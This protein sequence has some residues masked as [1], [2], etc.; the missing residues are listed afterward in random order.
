MS[1]FK[2][3][4]RASVISLLLLTLFKI[5]GGITFTIAGT[6][7][8]QSDEDFAFDFTGDDDL[9]VEVTSSDETISAIRK[10]W[11]VPD[12]ITAYVGK[13]FKF[14]FPSDAFTKGVKYYEVSNF[15]IFSCYN[16]AAMHKIGSKQYGLNF[17][18]NITRLSVSNNIK[19]TLQIIMI[20][21]LLLL[22]VD[23]F[24]Y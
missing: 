9:M 20:F 21:L 1:P 3:V 12:D 4:W 7:S 19:Q 22:N 17:S 16:S 8:L 24:K 11:G 23:D 2:E 5:N 10:L 18:I 14:D 6:E 15:T 13:I